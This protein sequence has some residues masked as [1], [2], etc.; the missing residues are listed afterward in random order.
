MSVRIGWQIPWATQ[1]QIVQILKHTD[2]LKN[3][4]LQA[5]FVGRTY[6]PML[7]ELAM[8]NAL[9]VVLTGDLP[10]L[11]L[12]A[13]ERGWR[14]IGRLM[15]NRTV[16]YVPSESPLR[17]IKDLDRAGGGREAL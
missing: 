17:E 9:D 3:N 1:G 10:G 13:K 6:G 16:T 4:G 8:A 15:Y 11:T 5:S 14:A 7:N 2:I 12:I